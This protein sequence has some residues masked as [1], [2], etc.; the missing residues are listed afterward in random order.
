MCKKKKTQLKA[1]ILLYRANTNHVLLGTVMLRS[2][3]N[4]LLDKASP[5]A[6]LLS[7]RTENPERTFCDC[8]FK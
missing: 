6:E 8:A 4:I 2:L 1:Q 5:V 3:Q 7:W